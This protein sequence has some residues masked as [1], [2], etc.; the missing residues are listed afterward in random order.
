M[1]AHYEQALDKYQALIRNPNRWEELTA[2]PSL[3]PVLGY[4]DAVGWDVVLGTPHDR[5]QAAAFLEDLG[6]LLVDDYCFC[7]HS[8]WTKL[9]FELQ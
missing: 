3:Q 4:A 8:D 5:N 1:D 2:F 9:L 6:G 7:D